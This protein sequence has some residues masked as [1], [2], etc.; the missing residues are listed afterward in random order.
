MA[1]LE[2]TKI[3]YGIAKN[4]YKEWVRALPRNQMLE[5]NENEPDISLEQLID[6]EFEAKL[7][8]F[9]EELHSAIK[10]LNPT[11]RDV[12][13]MRY[14]ENMTRKEVAE[15]L[16]IKEKHVHVYQRRGITALQKIIKAT[17][18]P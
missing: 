15:K 7:D 16:G 12:M 2:P 18:I 6:E 17:S 3:L 4:R 8:Q 1:E 9:R 14:L 11:L 13:R 10:Q 5:L